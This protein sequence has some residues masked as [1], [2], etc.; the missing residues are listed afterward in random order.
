[1]WALAAGPSVGADGLREKRDQGPRVWVNAGASGVLTRPPRAAGLG[2]APSVPLWLAA[3][4]P[5]VRA[6]GSAW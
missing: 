1:M 5:V 3:R 4:P 6:P 2:S